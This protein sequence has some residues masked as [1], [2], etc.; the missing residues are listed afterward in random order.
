[1]FY[2][3][4]FQQ[5]SAAIYYNSFFLP[6]NIK[7]I[8]G[9]IINILYSVIDIIYYI[10]ITHNVKGN[11]L[12]NF[13]KSFKVTKIILKNVLFRKNNNNINICN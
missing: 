10:N 5:V 8:L 11:A 3:L 7:K 6:E 2:S 12:S 1:L 4:H 13:F 9:Y